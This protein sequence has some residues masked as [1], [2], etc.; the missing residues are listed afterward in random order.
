MSLRDMIRGFRRARVLASPGE[1]RQGTARRVPTGRGETR[2]GFLAFSPCPPCL[3]VERGFAFVFAR[4]QPCHRPAE[5]VGARRAVPSPGKGN[6]YGVVRVVAFSPVETGG[7]FWDVPSGHD[8]RFPPGA[9]FGIARRNPAGHGA[10]CPYRAGRNGGTVFSLFLCAL[11]VS[12][13]SVLK[14]VTLYSPDV[15]PS[16]PGE[17]HARCF[18]SNLSRLFSVS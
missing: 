18:P 9:G 7:Y 5:S 4:R 11:R 6:P 1:T 14:E 16:T 13:F 10:L 3:R 2:N 12:V 17:T 15:S 8:S